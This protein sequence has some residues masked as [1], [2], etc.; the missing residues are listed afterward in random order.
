MSTQPGSP[1]RKCSACGALLPDDAPQGLCPACLGKAALDSEAPSEGSIANTPTVQVRPAAPKV[2]EIARHFPQLE[3]LELLGQGGM[4]IVY[5]ARQPKLDRLVALKILPR[6]I[7]AD[8]AFAERFQ[9]EARALAK[10]SHPNI[11]AVH[12]VGFAETPLTPPLSPH[13]MRGEGARR[14]GEG[15]Q[16]ET[17]NPKPETAGGGFY[18]LLM[19]Y[20]DGMNLR[21]LERSKQ[22][23]PAEALAIIPKICEAL[24][25][26]HDEG[27]VHRDIKP[28]NI[29]VDTKGRVK[30]AD[31]GLAKLLGRAPTD[32]TLTATAAVMGT[33]HYMAPEQLEGTSS[34][35][36]RADIYS[37]GVVF[38]E[39][40]TGS[41]PVGRFDLPSQRVQ[42]D[43]RLDE[44]VLKALEQ[45][46]DRRYQKAS[47]V[48]TDVESISSH[49]GLVSPAVE[50]TGR[51]ASTEAIAARLSTPAELM[52]LVAGTALLVAVGAGLWVLLRGQYS[53]ASTR[54]TLTGM[55]ICLAIYGGVIGFAS[56]LLRRM[57]ARLLCLLMTVL[58]GVIVPAALAYNVVDQLQH[59]PQWPVVIP[60][61]LGVPVAGWV[62]TLLF[63]SDV[64]EAFARRNEERR[65]GTSSSEP[66]QSRG[67]PAPMVAARDEAI[68]SQLPAHILWGLFGMFLAG[69]LLLGAL[70]NLGWAGLTVGGL[71][72]CGMLLGGMH[73]IA[74]HLPPLREAI[75]EQSGAL[76]L[77]RTAVA[78]LLFAVAVAAVVRL[79]MDVEARPESKDANQA[80]NRIHSGES[81]EARQIM[82]RLP[83]F[84]AS[85]AA[86]ADKLW[87]GGG[88]WHFRGSGSVNRS[89]AASAIPLTLILLATWLLAGTPRFRS[90]WPYRRKPG[91]VLAA[92][93]LGS[94]L[95]LGFVN[96]MHPSSS[97]NQGWPSVLC[98][99]DFARVSQAVDAWAQ[100]NGYE[101][102]GDRNNVIRISGDGLSNEVGRLRVVSLCPKSPFERYQLTLH[103][104]RRPKPP[105]VLTLVGNVAAPHQT[106][107]SLDA[108]SYRTP[109]REEEEWQPLL[110][111]L[112]KRLETV[113]PAAGGS[114]GA[115]ASLRHHERS[116]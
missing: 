74:S 58:A 88:N 47:E 66:S 107:V 51:A 83:A 8:P 85:V 40:L 15:S 20:V 65:T 48:K 34:V 33:P 42:V 52:M 13:P 89:L 84:K 116:R 80:M 2:E 41:L 23:S 37:L 98:E 95:L 71:M 86:S 5:K 112:I 106:H 46:P 99:E 110:D 72:L 69:W 26:A 104:V 10:L 94:L 111:Q 14:A 61:W 28:E 1:E 50:F 78:L 64:R 31:F 97:W 43:V 6:N 115:G 39:M 18:Y 109:S 82:D 101:V 55:S 75:H 114:E 49:G 56:M 77:A 108:G 93:C 90:S 9:R 81:S 12:D 76:R 4:G 79:H 25:F 32:H 16:L 45:S 63:R 7:A 35:D 54:A 24:Q 3:I 29:L 68:P 57:Q 102:R 60:L 113:R 44:V 87:I 73:W 103:G 96:V 70:W 91:L 22:L 92:G 100:E 59:I 36:H 62:V 27:I 11:V 19:E 105:L 38:Y 53:E 30:I 17:S 21:Q 67:G